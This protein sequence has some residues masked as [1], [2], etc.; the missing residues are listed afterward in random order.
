LA[1][2]A[3]HLLLGGVLLVHLLAGWALWQFAGK[4]A[5]PNKPEPIV[6]SL[7][8]A[9]RPPAPSPKLPPTPRPTQLETS[10]PLKPLLVPVPVAASLSPQAQASPQAATTA[11]IS[12]QIEAQPQSAPPSS[13]PISNPGPRHVAASAVRY[14]VEPQLSVPLQSRRLGE[15]GIVHLRIVI[16]AR[17]HLKEASLKKSAGFARLDQQALHDIR[18]ARFAP[19]LEDGQPVEWETVALLSYEIER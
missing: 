17:G 7:I 1:K 11:A 9:A 12:A 2:P 13:G 8:A 4:R 16:D 5:V 15:S 14:L 18:S 6:L 10:T 19:Y 3:R